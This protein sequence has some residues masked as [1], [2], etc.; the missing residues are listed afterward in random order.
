[1]GDEHEES[2]AEGDKPVFILFGDQSIDNYP[3]LAQFFRR[4]SHSELAKAFLRQACHAL[5]RQIEKLPAD[6]RKIVPPFLTIQQLNERYR[7]SPFKHSGIDAALLTVSQIAHY[8][9]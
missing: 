7:A 6:E 1:M 8:L 9:E 3:F 5:Q 4:E 2:W